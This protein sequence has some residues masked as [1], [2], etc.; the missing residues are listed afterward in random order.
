MINILVFVRVSAGCPDCHA[1]TASS[2]SNV[3]GA[4]AYNDDAMSH[5]PLYRRPTTH[6]AARWRFSLGSVLIAMTLIS[7]ALGVFRVVPMTH[8]MRVALLW[9]AGV[10]ALAALLWVGPGWLKYT[11]LQQALDER[12]AQMQRWTDEQRARHAAAVNSATEIKP[13]SE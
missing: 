8:E 9:L 11:R 4:V 2:A 6:R 7:L 3:R 13:P 1:R 12:K 10:W 5:E